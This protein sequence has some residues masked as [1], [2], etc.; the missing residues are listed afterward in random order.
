MLIQSESQ[1]RNLVKISASKRRMTAKCRIS[2]QEG[3]NSSEQMSTWFCVSVGVCACTQ[4]GDK[5][6]LSSPICSLY[7][8]GRYW[9][10]EVCT[11]PVNIVCHNLRV[12]F[13]QSFLLSLQGVGWRDAFPP[14]S[15]GGLTRLRSF[16]RCNIRESQ[17]SWVWK[18]PLEVIW[19]KPPAPAGSPRTGCPGPCPY[20]N[21]EGTKHKARGLSYLMCAQQLALSRNSSLTP[22]EVWKVTLLQHTISPTCA[23]QSASTPNLT[24]SKVNSTST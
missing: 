8:E 24:L 21:A 4:A 10:S 11:I 6:V 12:N 17:K 15:R 16:G 7:P 1:H 3:A 19:P 23:V 22:Y 18:C 2:T 9:S 20:G 14:R 13:P 5:G